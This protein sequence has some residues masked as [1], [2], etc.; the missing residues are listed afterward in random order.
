MDKNKIVS[1]VVV[2]VVVLAAVAYFMFGNKVNPIANN[3]N[4]TSVATVNGVAIPKATYDTQLASA[5]SSYKAQGVDV[6]DVTKLA[7]IKTQVLDNLINN[8]LVAQGIK[9][10][11][12]TVTP[13]EIDAQVQTIIQQAGGATQYQAELKTANL[14]EAQLRDNISNQL[15]IQK[16][17][18]AN[19][20]TASITVSDAEISQFYTDYSKA[21]IAASS[22][23]KVPALKD[24]SAQI[25]QQL[26]SNKQQVLINDFLASLRSK[27]QI[28]TSTTL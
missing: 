19:V 25:K 16:Y 7:Q 17:L 4:N 18:A 15:A 3:T 21:Q 22:T 23:I 26:T 24:L 13:A 14:T 12:I 20:N 1:M 11:G 5:I 8:E 9:S 28:A 6:A 27:A 10:A 2:V